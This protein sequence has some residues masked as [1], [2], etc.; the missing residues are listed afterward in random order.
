MNEF[1]HLLGLV[2]PFVRQY[3][4]IAVPIIITLESLGAPCLGN[5]C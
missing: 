4:L 5:R 3:G 2:D 1:E